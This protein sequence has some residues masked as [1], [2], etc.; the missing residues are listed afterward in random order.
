MT[1]QIEGSESQK[2]REFRDQAE[3]GS[4]TLL[5]EYLAFL[6]YDKKWWLAP[7][8]LFL[9]LLGT[10]MILA[11]TSASTFIYTLF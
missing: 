1:D 6:R 11:G 8:I 10:L 3:L 4:S 9:T 2:A 5:G 7:V